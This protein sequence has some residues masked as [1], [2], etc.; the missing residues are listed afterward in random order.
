MGL[1]ITVPQLKMVVDSLINV[2]N[3][4]TGGTLVNV[5][6]LRLTAFTQQITLNA[7]S[8]TL[9]LNIPE[10]DEVKDVINI[11]DEGIFL[12]PSDYSI[13]GNDITINH[14][15]LKDHVI[16]IMVFKVSAPHGGA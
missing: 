5:N 3:V 2:Q 8:S 14:T 6:D 1:I 7:D 13:S 11:L 9:T 12:K 15:L 10:Y 16:T 4:L